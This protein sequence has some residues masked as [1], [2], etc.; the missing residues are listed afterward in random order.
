MDA[1]KILG[2]LLI[3]S[4]VFIVFWSIQSTYTNFIGQTEFPQ[5]FQLD[6]ETIISKETSS[7]SI[8]DNIG[9]IIGEQIKQ[10][11]PQASTILMLNMFSWIML[12]SFLVFAGSKL[13]G[14][15]ASLLKSPKKEEKE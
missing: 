6:E 13:V 4:G 11:L 15:G 12:A 10:M 3:I 2:W 8:E 7:G 1:K 9:S 14:M 5:L